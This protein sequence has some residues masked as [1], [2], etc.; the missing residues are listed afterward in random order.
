MK[1]AAA[2]TLYNPTKEQ[3]LHCKEYGTSFDKVYLLDNSE[4]FDSTIKDY[5]DSETFIYIKLNGN[6]GLSKAFNVVLN[7]DSINEYDYLCTIDQDSIFES[8]D[9]RRIKAFIERCEKEEVS[10]INKKL[11]G[12]IAPVIDYGKNVFKQN[13]YE[14]RKRVITSGAFLKISSLQKHNLRYDEKYFI[15]K[16]EIDL[17]QQFINYGFKIYV[18]FEAVLHQ[19]LGDSEGRKH[20]VHS[21]LRHYYLFRNRFYFNRKFFG[22]PKRVLFNILQTG[23]HCVQILLYE[24]CKL[25]KLMQLRVAIGDYLNDNMGKK[26]N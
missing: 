3:L 2:I 12:I 6:E 5:Y 4:N 18:F 10:H 17:C 26:E 15:D 22:V 20:S 24:P 13:G 25:K 23:R 8:D 9:I 7:S 16:F 21:S 19:H 14:E 1:F 11:I